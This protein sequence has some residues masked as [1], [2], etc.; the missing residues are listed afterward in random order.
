MIERRAYIY[1]PT[2]DGKVS[3]VY[4]LSIA[5]LL[6]EMQGVRMLKTEVGDFDVPSMNAVANDLVRARSMAVH[7]FL[8]ET[9]GTDFV[10]I[11]ADIGFSWQLLPALMKQNKEVIACTYPRKEINWM[12]ATQSAKR[13]YP[14]EFGAYDY[15]LKSE[16]PTSSTS[17]GFHVDGTGLGFMV[18]SR[19]AL[20]KM[21]KHYYEEKRFIEKGT[22]A[23]ALFDLIIDPA[24]RGL[25]SEDYSFCKRWKDIGGNVHL[26][27]GPYSDIAHVGAH[28]Y[29]G[30]LQGFAHIHVTK[31]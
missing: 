12:R 22:E 7:K 2:H 8:N 10:F 19:T 28:T 6:Y 24:T 9:D 17:D 15:V 27:L 30:S 18:I 21:V 16:A 4:H 13:G 11:D 20:E 25:L 5:K 14:A 3:E 29:Q 23:V 31:E 1:T 26:Y